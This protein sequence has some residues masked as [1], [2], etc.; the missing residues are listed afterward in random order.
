[1]TKKDI[2][3]A[4]Y[5][6]VHGDTHRVRVPVTR[7]WIRRVEGP[8]DSLGEWTF[9]N[10]HDA[11]WKLQ[12]NAK[13]VPEGG[14]YDK[15]DFTVTFADGFEYKGR[16]D[17]RN[18]EIVDIAAQIRAMLTWIVENERAADI[19]DA[20]EQAEAAS[21]LVTH[22][23]QQLE[24]SPAPEDWPVLRDYR[25]APVEQGEPALNLKV[26]GLA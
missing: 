7:I 5:I 2:I 10:W 18:G 13:T 16:Y 11:N 24:P 1:M 9:T 26:Y 3:P 6:G 20:D 25:Q 17:L 8:L 12:M 19:F 15:H 23:L 22:D 21:R 4:A 14:C